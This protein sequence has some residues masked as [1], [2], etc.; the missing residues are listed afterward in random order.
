VQFRTVPLPTTAR[1]SCDLRG[2]LG[3]TFKP[4]QEFNE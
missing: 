1:R 4:F 3:S 2:L